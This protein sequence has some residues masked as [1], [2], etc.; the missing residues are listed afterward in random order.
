MEP[1]KWR[2]GSDDFPFQTADFQVPCQFS[3][4]YIFQPRDLRYSTLSLFS[5]RD[6]TRDDTPISEMAPRLSTVTTNTQAT[7]ATQVWISRVSAGIHGY[8]DLIHVLKGIK[9]NSFN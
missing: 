3:R 1:Q 8:S 7:Q 2:F 4:V 9:R 5:T 6:D